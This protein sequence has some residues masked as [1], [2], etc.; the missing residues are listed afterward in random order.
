MSKYVLLIMSSKYTNQRI[1]KRNCNK[2]TVFNNC[3]SLE[4]FT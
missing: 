2:E 3:S 4:V 1:R